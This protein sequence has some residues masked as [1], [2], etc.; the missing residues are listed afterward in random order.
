MLNSPILL[1]SELHSFDSWTKN[2]AMYIILVYIHYI[3][4]LLIN[5]NIENKNVLLVPFKFCN[6]RVLS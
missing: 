1:Y 5:F 4:S 2:N 3:V 6:S